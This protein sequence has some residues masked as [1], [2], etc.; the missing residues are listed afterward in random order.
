VK[1]DNAVAMSF[2]PGSEWLFAK[3]YAS[4]SSFNR[5]LLNVVAPLVDDLKQKAMIDR[6]FF[7]RYSDDH[8]HLRVRLHSSKPDGSGLLETVSRQLNAH[9]GS[10][11]R[12][13][14]AT[15]EREVQRYGGL[16]P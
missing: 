12:L 14:F 1:V 2:M 5:L 8:H 15:Y 7:I 11:W 4:P 6:Y 9:E 3:L 16:K 13:E 10:F